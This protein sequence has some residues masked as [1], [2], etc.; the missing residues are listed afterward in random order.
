M[1]NASLGNK[2][3]GSD[4]SVSPSDVSVNLI[5]YQPASPLARHSHQRTFQALPDPVMFPDCGVEI[6]DAMVCREK[7]SLV[8]EYDAACVQDYAATTKA[9]AE[10]RAQIRRIYRELLKHVDSVRSHCERVREVLTVLSTAADADQLVARGVAPLG[11][12]AQRPRTTNHRSSPMSWLHGFSLPSIAHY[13]SAAGIL[14]VGGVCAALHHADGVLT[15][16][17]RKR[18]PCVSGTTRR[19]SAQPKSCGDYAVWEKEEVEAIAAGD[20]RRR[21]VE[22]QLRKTRAKRDAT[23]TVLKEHTEE[24][25]RL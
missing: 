12:K 4:R 9:L 19:R 23:V 2:V 16:M 22:A 8:A 1:E 11:G 18:P 15:V 25:G 14:A 17:E 6:D 10:M 21:E 13:A 24:D 20:R 5:F 3:W 7:R